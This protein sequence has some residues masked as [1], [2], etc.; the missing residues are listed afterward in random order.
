[1]SNAHHSIGRTLTP[2]AVAML[3]ALPAAD[4]L[5]QTG[6]AFVDDA[7]AGMTLRSS[8]FERT[9]PDE[10][11]PAAEA[12]GLGGWI[13]GET[14]E[15]ADLFKI[16]GNYYFVG[17]LYGPKDGGGNFVLDDSQSSYGVLGEAWAQLR[18]GDH[19][20]R[21]GR[22]A[23]S[24][25]WSLDGVYRFFNR[26]DGAFIG[27][28]DVRAMLPLN[29]ESATVSGKFANDTVRYY[30]GYAWN[31]RQINS[32][33]FDDLAEGALLPGDSD[34]M[35]FVG[36]QWKLNNDMMLQGAYHAVDNLLNMGWVDFDT[37]WRLG[38]NKYVRFD[39][40]YIYQSSNG[41]EYLGN[42]ST[43]N[44]AAYVEARWVGWAI[45][46]ATIGFN[47]DGDE[48]RAPYSLGPSY[49]VQRVGENAKAGERTW[50]IGTHF[51]FAG[52]GGPGLSFDINYGQR[53]DRHVAGN[54]SQPLSDWDELATDLIYN[55]GKDVGWLSGTRVRFRWA[56]VWEG[57]R[58][59]SNGGIVPVDQDTTDLRFDFQ[60]PISFL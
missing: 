44:W 47:G 40:Q 48:I 7:K 46:Y 22:Q 23:L 12:W 30:G 18:F 52:L 27:R 36:A 53:R 21:L 9:R 55:F 10:S 32:D 41:K 5:A 24:Y 37:V 26:Y 49:L 50:I 42:F 39:T 58:Q 14:G 1:M 60:V 11:G 16:G 59:Y 8:F 45:P 6:N 2:V 35:A 13:G 43:W 15:V 38:D 25:G 33:S 56:K 51:D 31:M 54:S 17:E 34:G 19:A 4:A 28:R 57:G 20:L 29:F 3:A